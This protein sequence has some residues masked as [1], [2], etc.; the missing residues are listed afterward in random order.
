[1]NEDYKNII[2]NIR[3]QR[4]FD[5]LI[6]RLS[7]KGYRNVYKGDLLKD[8]VSWAQTGPDFCI[9]LNNHDNYVAHDHIRYYKR[10]Y[11]S[12]PI[13][14][15]DEYFRLHDREFNQAN[16]N[17]RLIEAIKNCVST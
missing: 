16:L 10:E 13:L 3:T 6:S 17:K 8:W 4:E 9:R 15:V 12:Y 11:R 14:T 7:D 5:V 2:I 1:M